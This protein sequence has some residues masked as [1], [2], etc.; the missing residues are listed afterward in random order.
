M[1]GGTKANPLR[2]MRESPGPRQSVGK[3]ISP[4]IAAVGSPANAGSIAR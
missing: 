2:K 3:R 4:Y 1:L